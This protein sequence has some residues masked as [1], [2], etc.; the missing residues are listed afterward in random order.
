MWNIYQF[1]CLCLVDLEKQKMLV[2]PDTTRTGMGKHLKPHHNF[3]RKNEWICTA[4]AGNKIVARIVEIEI[5][6]IYCLL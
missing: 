1:V 6:I 3:F 2:K 4:A 5:W